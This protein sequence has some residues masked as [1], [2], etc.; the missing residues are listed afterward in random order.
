MSM[1]CALRRCLRGADIR[2]ARPFM[3][4]GGRSFMRSRAYTVV[5]LIGSGEAVIGGH[6][7]GRWQRKGRHG[8]TGG[9][10]AGH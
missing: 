5:F 10:V 9:R 2:G 6:S 7:G 8:Y 3:C 4:S 1:A